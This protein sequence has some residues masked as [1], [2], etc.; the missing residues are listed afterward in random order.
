MPPLTLPFA[1][2]NL[3]RNPFGELTEDEWARLAVLELTSLERALDAP[4]AAVQLVGDSGRGKTT[5]LL[6]LSHRAPGAQRVRVEPGTRRLDA[7]GDPLLV[8]EAQFLSRRGR[9]RLFAGPDRLVL[10]THVDLASELRAAGRSPVTRRLDDGPDA[11][12]LAALVERRIEAARRGPGPL[13]RVRGEALGRLRAEHGSNVRALIGRLYEVF[14][15]M[16][17][18]GDAQV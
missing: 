8:D 16:K 4:R 6:A 14:Q 15:Q 12:T 18:I 3:R 13:P 17:E 9:R 5:H 2:L 10:G 11:A 1:H 7:S